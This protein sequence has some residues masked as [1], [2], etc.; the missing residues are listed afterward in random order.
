[1]IIAKKQ[2]EEIK[3]TDVDLALLKSSMKEQFELEL[4]T[5]KEMIEKFEM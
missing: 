4:E 1:L 5:R 2:A 3:R